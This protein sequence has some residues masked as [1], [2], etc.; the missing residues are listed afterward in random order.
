MKPISFARSGRG[1]GGVEDELVAHRAAE[2]VVDRLL[3]HLAEEVPQREVDAA[4]GVQ[5]DP[6]APVVQRG[7]VHLVPDLLDVGDQ[8]ALDEPGEVLLDDPGAE[9]AAGGDGETD[10][11]VV[12]LDLDDQR[13]EHVDA[14]R[15][16]A[17]PVL[18]V[19][20]HRGGDVVVDPVAGVLVVVVGAAA[21][22]HG[23]GRADRTLIASLA[24]L[25]RR[26]AQALCTD[27]FAKLA[28]RTPSCR[29]WEDHDLAGVELTR[30]EP[31]E[32]GRRVVEADAVVDEMLQP[33][34]GGTPPTR[35]SPGTRRD[36]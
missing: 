29:P 9:L 16:A 7:Q 26:C 25:G 18:G 27:S 36:G 13:A 35:R 23:R 21:A 20:R 28:H 2:Q 34:R 33:R 8:L 24:A 31:G 22:D 32:G 6:L 5:D 4:D 1:A 15:L 17:L 19:P 14:E 30:G 10:R 12:G 3:P 11:A